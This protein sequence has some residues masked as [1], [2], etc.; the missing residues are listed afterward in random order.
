[1]LRVLRDGA[2]QASIGAEAS[3]RALRFTWDVTANEVLRVYDEVVR[4]A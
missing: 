3:R 1:M 2:L 4:A